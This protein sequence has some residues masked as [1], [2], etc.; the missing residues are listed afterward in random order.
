MQTFTA[1][2]FYIHLWEECKDLEECARGLILVCACF[3]I[4]ASV[5][6]KEAESLK[7]IALFSCLAV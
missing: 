5:Y 3:C 4:C 1:P 2:L 6:E 7:L